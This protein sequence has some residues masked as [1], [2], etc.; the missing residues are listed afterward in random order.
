MKKINNKGITMIEI[1]VVFI[2]T[3]TITI[4][5]YKTIL[6]FKE[7][8]D[9]EEKKEKITTYKNLVTNDIQMDIIKKKLVD[10]QIYVGGQ[11]QLYANKVVGKYDANGKEYGVDNYYCEYNNENTTL[12]NNCA[13]YVA[14]LKFQ[15]GSLKKLQIKQQLAAQIEEFVIYKD[16][17]EATGNDTGEITN[18]VGEDPNSKVNDSFEILYGDYTSATNHAQREANFIDRAENY[19]PPFLGYS[20]NNYNKKV[21]DLRL[22]NVKLSVINNT[23]T[24]YLGMNYPDLGERYSINI[25]APLQFTVSTSTKYF[26]YTGV[27]QD[28]IIQK[29][30]VYRL[31]ACG[32]SG[33]G[34]KISENQG[35]I[36]GSGGCVEAYRRFNMNDSIKIFVGGTT[37]N[38]TGGTNGNSIADSGKGGDGKEPGFGGG[39]S[40]EI[41]LNNSRLIVGAGGGGSDNNDNTDTELDNEEKPFFDGSGGRGGGNYCGE[42]KVNGNYKTLSNNCNSTSNGANATTSGAGGG[43]GGF[44]GGNTDNNTNGGGCGGTSYI[45]TSDG[46]FDGITGI[47]TN[48][49]NGYIYIS[50][51]SEE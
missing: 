22:E 15:D 6:A 27:Q 1:I 36:G 51:V 25:V 16:P 40:S 3:S 47:D 2:L 34:N 11:Q 13:M 44:L 28:Y 50:L 10:V 8:Q 29:T 24:A 7:K 20:R 45:N 37:T 19:T 32:A 21:F 33:G 23:F 17:E 30:G 35:S 46:V 26:Y 38:A 41:W 12:N 4:S 18:P 39:A 42:A 48:I 31:K 49:G 9:Q 5:M 14:I 43:G